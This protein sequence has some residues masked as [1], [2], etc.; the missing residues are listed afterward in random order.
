MFGSF[1][2]MRDACPVCG[3]RFTR[4]PGF[5]Q[6]AMFVSYTVGVAELIV[7]STI[8]Y[9]FLS[10]H[11]GVGLALGAAGIVHLVLVPQLFVYSRVIWA[12]I[13]AE[14]GR[15]DRRSSPPPDDF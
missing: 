6:G 7:G 10:P 9:V 5:F 14:S 13:F 12:H 2:A 15:A 3:H 4:E 8:A 1:M 11:I